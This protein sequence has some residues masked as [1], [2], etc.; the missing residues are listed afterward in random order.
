[1]VARIVLIAVGGLQKE[2]GA[3][4]INIWRRVIVLSLLGQAKTPWLVGAEES[5]SSRWQRVVL[6]W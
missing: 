6:S 1:V 2:R 3:V 5:S 4:T